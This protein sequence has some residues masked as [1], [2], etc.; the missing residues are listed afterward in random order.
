MWS[1]GGHLANKTFLTPNLKALRKL[2]FL[3][4]I[5]TDK[6]GFD[7]FHVHLRRNR[8]LGLWVTDYNF[9]KG[10]H[11]NQAIV[12]FDLFWQIQ[13]YSPTE[14]SQV[15]T[16][17]HY[18]HDKNEG[19]GGSTF[20]WPSQDNR[21]HKVQIRTCVSDISRIE[22]VHVETEAEISKTHLQ[23]MNTTKPRLQ[24]TKLRTYVFA[25]IQRR[26]M[27]PIRELRGNIERELVNWKK[28][29]EFE[30]G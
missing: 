28:A 17:Q 7:N 27:R 18:K 9:I 30:E 13:T 25:R 16:L 26:R 2:R 21:D 10:F 3:V 11:E 12:A 29:R 6:L 20:E 23:K 19:E 1:L 8:L 24:P 5:K 4:N 14:F 15:W 22:P